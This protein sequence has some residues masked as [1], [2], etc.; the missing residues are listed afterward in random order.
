MKL[1]KFPVKSWRRLRK[2]ATG[3]LEHREENKEHRDLHSSLKNYCSGVPATFVQHNDN[4][5]FLKRRK[6]TSAS[7]QNVFSMGELQETCGRIRDNKGP[8]LEWISYKVANRA[9]KIRPVR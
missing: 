4:S 5:Y 2:R 3:K 6:W 1:G 9:T 8:E 7:N